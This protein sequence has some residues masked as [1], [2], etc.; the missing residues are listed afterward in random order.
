[1]IASGGLSGGLSSAIAGGNFWS[2]VREGLI[3]SGLNHAMHSVVN[4]IQQNK[5]LKDI[6]EENDIDPKGK[7]KYRVSYAKKIAKLLPNN[8]YENSGD[9]DIKIEDIRDNG[10]TDW[11]TTTDVKKSL[12]LSVKIN[13]IGLSENAFKSNLQLASTLFHELI[14]V[15]DILSGDALKWLNMNN[16]GNTDNIAFGIDMMEESALRIQNQYVPELT[17]MI[18]YNTIKDRLSKY[19]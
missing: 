16:N 14:H 2:G 18:R 10:V 11:E 4:K 12:H 8:L 15:R 13:H 9:V 17:D 6:L 3:T 7:A 19:K 5:M 1:M